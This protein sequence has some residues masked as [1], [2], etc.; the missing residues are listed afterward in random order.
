MAYGAVDR[1]IWNDE[2]FR[3]WREDVR[4]VWLYLLTCPHGN[5]LGCFVLPTYYVADDV[6]L[7]LDVAREALATLEEEGRIA[8]DREL[9]VVCIRNHLKPE[10]NPLANQ[11]VVKA[12]MKDLAELPDSR[13]CLRALLE[14]V[15]RWGRPHYE[16]LEQELRHRVGDGVAH[17]GGQGAGHGV[18]HGGGGSVPHPDPDPDPEHTHHARG[19]GGESEEGGKSSSPSDRQADLE[20]EDAVDVVWSHY[21]SRYAER[22]S[23]ARADRLKLTAAGR[24]GKIRG[25]LRE[26]YTPD[27]LCRAIDGCFDDQWHAE[28]QKDDLEYIL[29]NQS[30]VEDFLNRAERNGGPPESR[31]DGREELAAMREAASDG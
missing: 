2:R 13:K 7:E 8:W 3:R 16:Q 19:T 12:A 23:Q 29:R 6:Q 25:R 28:R 22:Y 31:P 21:V 9:R 11:S 17:G 27:E 15:D 1:R 24:D 26:D 20:L 4:M 10:Y 30:K 5:R 14:A 18:A